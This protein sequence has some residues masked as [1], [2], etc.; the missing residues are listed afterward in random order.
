MTMKTGLIQLEPATTL[1]DVYKTMSPEPLMTPP[2]IRAFYQ[3][4]LN[5]VRGG[6]K[7]GAMAL[8]LERCRGTGFYKAFLMGHPGVGKSTE[9]TRLV[10]HMNGRFRAIRFQVT[11]ELNPGCFKPFD[12]LL[13]MMIRVVEETSKPVAEG[14]AGAAPSEELLREVEAWFD[15]EK[16]K[17]TKSRGVGLDGSAGIGPPAN[18]LWHKV[19]GLFANAKGELKYAANRTDEVVEYRLA[20]VS[21]LM[22]LVNKLLDECNDLLRDSTGCEWLFIGEDFD[23]PGIRP[24]LVEDFFLNYA[25]IFNDIR[26]HSIFTI[27]IGLAYSAKST[28]LPCPARPD[29]YHP[30]HTGLRP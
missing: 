21:N 26:A 19:T 22:E 13:L 23:K 18:T 25:N 27:P 7:V 6:D 24:G 29:P 16:V 2:E 3:G 28:Q 12:V 15:D 5:Q 9:L 30:G 4:E 1:D 8:G 10:E 20:R 11:K 17:L 14:G